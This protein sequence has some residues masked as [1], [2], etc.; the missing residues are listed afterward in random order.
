MQNKYNTSIIIPA[1][2]EQEILESAVNQVLAWA[3]QNTDKVELII[4]EN[5]STDE[6]P[7]IVD[8]LASDNSEVGVLHLKEANFG[9]AIKVAAQAAKH[10]RIILLNADWIDAEF[11]QR[12]LPLLDNNDIVVGSKVL[13]PSA[14][15]RPLLRKALSITLNVFIRTF[16][17]FKGS[18]SHGLKAFKAKSV[19]PI[20]NSCTSLEIIET[21][22]LLRAQWEGLK[23]VEVPVGI[24]ELR[25]PRVGI[26]RRS[27]VVAKE[28]WL[29][30]RSLRDIRQKSDS[31]LSSR[32]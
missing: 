27:V 16:F 28:L 20:I 30:N 29:L 2:N 14:D 21:E 3:R 32:G 6:T 1:F 9:K 11:M 18:D 22:M 26:A 13:D 4:A 31:K 10:E 8:R 5:G 7:S 17:K 25:P 23:T 15:R 19:V 24:E 12:A